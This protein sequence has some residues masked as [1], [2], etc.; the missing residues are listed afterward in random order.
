MRAPTGGDSLNAAA[1]IER[2]GFKAE[3][4][5]S[6]LQMCD[7]AKGGVGALL[8]S[9]EALFGAS[10]P[11]FM[12]MLKTQPSWSDVPIIV[13]T[14]GGETTQASLR[15]FNAF[16]PSG[17]IMLV[18]RPFRAITL[19]STLQVALR[20]RRRQ[21]QVR[22]LMN[23]LENRVAERTARLE[24]TVSEL[25]AFSYS[26][27]HDL[28]A[29]LRAMQGYSHFLMEDYGNRLDET[30]RDFLTRIIN[31][32][33]RLDRLVQDILTYSRFTRGEIEIHPINL[34][35]LVEEIVQHYP[36]LQPPQAEIKVQTPLVPVLGHD[37]SLTQCVSNL[38][39][40]AVK[41]M[42][43]DRIP[44]IKVW[45]DNIGPEVRVWFHDN[46][47][48]IDPA[49]QNRIF[50]MFERAPHQATYDGTGI[51]LAIVHKA[52]ERMG[53]K[54]GVDSVPGKGSK[55]WIQLPKA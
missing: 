25:E 52:V 49:H 18:E 42:P 48:G 51:G 38:L 43:P 47:I 31:S 11:G 19:V 32:G 4:C 46:G 14:S 54:V 33:N 24:E 39:S 40:N 53:G 29:P 15:A 8:V 28:R 26:V 27:S 30:G 2:A 50:K 5:E 41:F 44:R 10:L 22:E 12:E 21:Y 45:T 34:E 3:I 36:S 16:G 23:N 35:K 9:E 55:F 1:L 17:N 6:L 13:V 20:A 37:G 7:A